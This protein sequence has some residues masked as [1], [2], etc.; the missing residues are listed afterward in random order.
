VVDAI[1][2]L[3]ENIVIGN[4]EIS[5]GQSNLQ[6]DRD[7][8]IRSVLA[9]T[10]LAYNERLR[11]R[12]CSKTG[13]LQLVAHRAISADEPAL[14][15]AYMSLLYRLTFRLMGSAL[16]SA[17][18]GHL[19]DWLS[20][21]IINEALNASQNVS[22]VSGMAIGSAGSMSSMC[23]GVLANLTRGCAGARCHVKSQSNV[24]E[25]YRALTC[26]L[27]GT[28]TLTI[29]FALQALASLVLHDA[30]GATLFGKDNLHLISNIVFS[31]VKEADHSDQAL[32]ALRVASDLLCDLFASP[33][34]LE[35]AGNLCSASEFEGLFE[36]VATLRHS[37]D[38]AL[39]LVELACA[40]VRPPS[41]RSK[42]HA[43]LH[44][45]K[46][47]RAGLLLTLLGFAACP[48][49]DMALAAARLVIAMCRE[50]FS[51]FGKGLSPSECSRVVLE[52][53]TVARIRIRSAADIP[54]KGSRLTSRAACQVLH[55][56]SQ[57]VAFSEKVRA[58]VDVA[59]MVRE[60]RAALNEQDGAL[61]LSVLLL[62]FQCW[63]PMSLVE[64]QEFLL[65]AKS[66]LVVDTWAD[67]MSSEK[68]PNILVECILA[69]CM[70][71]VFR[72][73][74]K[75]C[76]SDGHEGIGAPKLPAFIE[77]QRLA[78]SLAAIH[79]GRSSEMEDLRFQIT[80]LQNDC[81]KER[82]N[83]ARVEEAGIAKLREEADA[84]DVERRRR[85]QELHS[86]ALELAET[87]RRRDEAI[88]SAQR[89][90]AALAQTRARLDAADRHI[91]DAEVVHAELLQR[92]LKAENLCRQMSA[93]MQEREA[94]LQR[95]S[96][97]RQGLLKE[98]EFRQRAERDLAE[99]RDLQRR[100]EGERNELFQEKMKL[101]QEYFL[102]AEAREGS[103]KEFKGALADAKDRTAEAQRR[104]SLLDARI[105]D[106]EKRDIAR[107]SAVKLL[108]KERDDALRE[109]SWL[110]CELGAFQRLEHDREIRKYHADPE[111]QA[112]REA[113]SSVEQQ[114]RERAEQAYAAAVAFPL[115][116]VVD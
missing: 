98:V 62:A 33:R 41:L 25:L 95:I 85:M 59:S 7:L 89:E 43:A 96:E 20:A 103:E 13:F 56:L 2:Q 39:P 27:V 49:T 101:Q 64:R 5:G 6:A 30:V 45:A 75:N 51:T 38:P 31:L 9:L 114:L 50:N 26:L 86:S 52:L 40:F 99:A 17:E 76:V 113:L 35:L 84:F 54:N 100:V 60:A 67:L 32:L 82:L 80:C 19:L 106:F 47:E 3:I 104:S 29:I 79:S 88:S 8:E 90:S 97:D 83:S 14:A 55:D 116:Q 63:E 66:K 44:S 42:L 1:P 91:E 77:M 65:F 111:L 92:A 109:A 10:S 73:P 94:E 46:A 87:Q 12:I 53:S 11:D 102:L 22:V 28:T 68:D 78:E 70:W 74:E 71:L 37:F 21:Y 34:V 16:L 69:S 107:D 115:R 81:A 108:E 58:Q 93:K 23:V 105:E 112:G 57:T 24:P 18:L 4:V 15:N 61:A 72:T 110:R 48:H 36:M